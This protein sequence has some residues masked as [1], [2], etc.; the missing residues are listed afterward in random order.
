[1]Y[2][3]ALFTEFKRMRNI[4]ADNKINIWSELFDK[5]LIF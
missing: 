4:G 5:L 2:L 1:M 3:K